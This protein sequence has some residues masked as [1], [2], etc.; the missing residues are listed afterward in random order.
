MSGLVA[1]PVRVLLAD[2]QEKVRSALRLLIEQELGF[3]VVGEASA[4]DELLHGILK[5]YPQIVLLDWELPGLPEAHKLDALRLIDPR[6]KIIA[7]SG[8]PE[9]RKSALAEGVDGFISKSEPP[10]GILRAL[11]FVH[12]KV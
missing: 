6:L 5:T 4:A 1:E 12:D 10:D 11:Y 2:D 3:F 7:L 9:A 8:A